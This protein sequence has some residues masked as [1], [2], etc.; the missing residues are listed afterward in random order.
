[1]ELQLQGLHFRPDL[2]HRLCFSLGEF[3]HTFVQV[4]VDRIDKLE[5][6]CPNLVNETF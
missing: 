3:Y 1:V 2:G 6:Y 5:P 4:S